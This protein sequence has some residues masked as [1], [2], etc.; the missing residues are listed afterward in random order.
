MTADQ[1]QRAREDYEDLVRA[2]FGTPA[3]R[4]LLDAWRERVL[5]APTY[6]P[7]DDLAAAAHAEGGKDFVRR[8]IATTTNP[9]RTA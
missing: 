5:A 8:I 9:S 1:R 6:Q 3:G 2:V 7:G 4:A